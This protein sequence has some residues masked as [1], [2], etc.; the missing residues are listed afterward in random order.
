MPRRTATIRRWIGAHGCADESIQ[1]SCPD[2]AVQGP[3]AAPLKPKGR[4][5]ASLKPKGPMALTCAG[6]QQV[7]C[8]AT[9]RQA[10]GDRRQHNCAAQ[11][12]TLWDL[13]PPLN[14]TDSWNTETLTAY[15]HGSLHVQTEGELRNLARSQGAAARTRKGPA[16]GR[17]GRGFV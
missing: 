1:L 13:L 6:E 8:T 16:S 10:G 12:E 14:V 17:G 5:K 3:T 2:D 15:A 7:V 9:R 4:L 11:A